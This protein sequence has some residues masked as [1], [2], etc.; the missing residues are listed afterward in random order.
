MVVV[1]CITGCANPK[2]A[3]EIAKQPEELT[4]P[5]AA[6]VTHVSAQQFT[7]ILMEAPSHPH[8]KHFLGYEDGLAYLEVSEEK[9]GVM[10]KE[11]YCI[12]KTALPNHALDTLRFMKKK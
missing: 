3:G 10:E 1:C 12:P 9:N 2:P 11:I 4:R 8:K 5:K 7:S 6:D